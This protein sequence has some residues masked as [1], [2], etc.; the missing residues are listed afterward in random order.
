MGEVSKIETKVQAKLSAEASNSQLIAPGVVIKRG[1]FEHS[2]Y[3]L[4]SI[5]LKCCKIEVHATRDKKDNFKMQTT[6]EV[7]LE[8]KNRGTKIIA[9]LNGAFYN[10]KGPNNKRGDNKPLG[11]LIYGGG[12][13][14]TP[15]AYKEVFDRD[16]KCTIM[17]PVY[18][19]NRC[20]LVI[21]RN[22]TAA[23]RQSNER[24]EDLLKKDKNIV[25]LMGG[26]GP[27]LVKE[28]GTKKFELEMSK[29]LK[30]V[31]MDSWNHKK[32]EECPRTAIG[33]TASGEVLICTFGQQYGE[34]KDKIGITSENLAKFMKDNGAVEA[35]VLDSGSSTALYIQE[36]GYAGV[37][38][39]TPMPTFL[40]IR[41]FSK[42]EKS[43][44]S[45]TKTGSAGQ[46][47][48]GGVCKGAVESA[49]KK[50]FGK[51]K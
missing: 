25:A 11:I 15:R 50:I 4:M 32:N 14:W 43:A 26:G 49:R 18:E 30:A 31:G 13:P 46:K 41:D 51:Y 21:N 42:E 28:A 20:C 8:Y 22:G 33:I 34:E 16:K 48:L 38:N 44:M 19:L 40:V 10:K 27:L 36:K 45:S 23:I 39:K 12:K 37:P 17:M 47:V 1:V 35:M 3:N 24:A 9:V 2:R 6:K 29:A 5:D 7:N